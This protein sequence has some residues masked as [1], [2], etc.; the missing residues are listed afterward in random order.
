MF[1]TDP[2]APPLVVV[3]WQTLALGPGATDL[4]YLVG[5]ALET[6][7]RRD[8]ERDLIEVYRNELDRRGVDY[9]IDTC[10]GDYALG[11]LH[12]VMV[13]ITATSV[14]EQTERGD[15]LFTLMLNR[16]GRHALDLEALAQVDDQTDR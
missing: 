6:D 15:A 4:A 16:H 7:H 5:G 12:G 14:A 10:L 13:A 9:P 11:A 2:S 1:G 3:D 8:A